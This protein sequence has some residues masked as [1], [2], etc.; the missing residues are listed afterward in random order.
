MEKSNGNGKKPLVKR[1]EKF[2]TS[3]VWNVSESAEGAKKYFLSLLRIVLTT[4]NGII[5]KR[6]LVQAS[7]LSY[8]TLLA[9]GPILAITVIFSGIFFRDK[10]EEFI[11]AKIMSAATFVMPAFNEMI[12]V[13]NSKG[14][15]GGSESTASLKSAPQINPRIFYFI[16]H[17]SKG[18][19]RAG[20]VGVAT[21]IVTCLL[22]CINMESAFN[23]IWGVKKGRR[24]V[25]RI[26]FY[27]AMI[28]FGSVGTIFGMTF[29]ATS[30]LN[31]FVKD[32]PF[33]SDYAS[34]LTYIIGIAV[35]TTVLAFFYKFIPCARV[36]WRAAFVGAVVII[37]ALILN[38]EMSFLYISYI[39]KQ[40]NFYGY[41][42]IVAVAM[43]SLYIFWMMILTGGQITFAV[44][45]VDFL[46]DDESWNKMGTRARELCALAV[47]GEISKAFYKRG[48]SPTVESISGSLRISKVVVTAS[49]E[50]LVSK[51][52]V[53]HAEGF[54]PDDDAV[55]FNPAVSPDTVK[56]SDFFA[57]LSTNEGD[58]T[59]SDMLAREEP[60]VAAAV[61]SMGEYSKGEVPSKTIRELI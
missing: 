61:A 15:K 34:W 35:M 28:F 53:C 42:A 13:E 33:I 20:A 49:L 31:S 5:H 26:V 16:N 17:I 9:I 2:L 23:Y 52:L 1:V 25:D 37:L 40:Q 30:Q 22:L 12:P 11:Y 4:I 8:A 36:K 32:I 10:G 21:M 27:F 47:F 55:Y 51:K 60:L 57:L 59:I 14:L 50:W 6:I 48:E 56:L 7:S 38:N 41:L 44:Q 43:F 39:V 18:S 19:S 24:W 3:D 46:S 58:S 54:N 45:Y 29:L